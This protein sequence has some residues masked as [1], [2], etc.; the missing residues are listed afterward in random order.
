MSFAKA[1]IKR[2]NEDKGKLLF[3][4]QFKNNYRCLLAGSKLSEGIRGFSVI[5]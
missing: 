4:I 5:L 2:F 3:Y 1:D